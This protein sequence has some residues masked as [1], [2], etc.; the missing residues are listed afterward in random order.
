[1]PPIQFL[2]QR[3]IRSDIC[4]WSM[5]RADISGEAINVTLQV[6]YFRNAK[7]YRDFSYTIFSLKKTSNQI[8]MPALRFKLAPLKYK[9]PQSFIKLFLFSFLYVKCFF[10]FLSFMK[11]NYCEQSPLICVLYR[12]RRSRK[13]SFIISLNCAKVKWA[14][15][16]LWPI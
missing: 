2:L 7:D 1:M 5:I 11:E 16:K 4:C 15:V 3:L 10:M 14:V 12:K 9:F 13:S 6:F 8:K